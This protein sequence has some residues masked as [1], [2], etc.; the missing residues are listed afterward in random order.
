MK[1]NGMRLLALLICVVLCVSGMCGAAMASESVCDMPADYYDAVS[2]FIN[3]ANWKHN[4]SYGS[5]QRPKSDAKP[6][7]V[8]SCYAYVTDFAYEVWKWPE[9]TTDHRPAHVGERFTDT[10]EIRPGDVI[11]YDYEIGNIK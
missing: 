1:K 6:T 9:G 8:K 7:S 2:A 11:Y 4:A 10:S 3:N 5:S